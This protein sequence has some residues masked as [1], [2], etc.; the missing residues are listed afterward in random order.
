MQIAN[1]TARLRVKQ[2]ILALEDAIASKDEASII[3]ATNKLNADLKVLSVLSGQNIK[4][5]DIKSILD[6]LKPADLIN[7]A[8]LDAA[9]AKIKEMLDLLA[10]ANLASTTKPATSASLGSGIPKGDFVAPVSMKD[11][12]AASTDALIEYADAA[13]ARANAFADLLDLQNAADLAALQQSS[14]YSN[15]GALQS[16]RTSESATV[17]IYAN[18]IANPDELTNLVQDAIIKINRQ[19]SSLTQAG[20][21]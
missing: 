5:A 11:A 19:G 2:D 6:S 7:Q 18:T 12:L 17:N 10:K 1:D 8:N 3:A 20:A 21:L 4:L 9:L 14:L 15:S 13:A 16:F